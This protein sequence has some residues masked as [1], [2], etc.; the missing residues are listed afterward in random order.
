MIFKWIIDLGLKAEDGHLA[1]EL[2]G[3]TLQVTKFLEPATPRDEPIA[4]FEFVLHRAVMLQL[5]T[6]FPLND[7]CEIEAAWAAARRRKIA[8]VGS[9]AEIIPFPHKPIDEPEAPE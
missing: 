7:V 6:I 3:L 4:D 9:G 5:L 2:R 1:D 8:V